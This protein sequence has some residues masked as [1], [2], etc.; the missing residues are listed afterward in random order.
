MKEYIY[1]L[2]CPDKPWWP[3]DVYHGALIQDLADS[4]RR[5]TYETMKKH[6]E[7]LNDWLLW[8]EIV[9]T[10]RG[11]AEFFREVGWIDFRKG[12]YDGMPAYFVVWSC[13]EF[14]WVHRDVL[15][16]RGIKPPVAPWKT[17]KKWHVD[18]FA[19]LRG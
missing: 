18:T 17:G 14:I 19:W 4:S 16:R 9:D 11:L 8:I 1:L 6:C 7:G 13:I 12:T 5:I 15:R 3:I 10:D 2:S